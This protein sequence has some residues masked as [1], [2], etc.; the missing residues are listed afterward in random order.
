MSV[1]FAVASNSDAAAIAALRMATSRALTQQ[2]GAG[3][4]SFAAESE[5]SVQAELRSSTVVFAREAGTI[6]A[7]AR[8]STRNPWIGRTD[9]FTPCARP[10]FLTA[11]AVT[12]NRQRQGVGRWLLLQAR[13]VSRELGGE[14]LRLDSYQ[15]PAGAGD[16]YRKCGF[17][18]VYRG[19]YNGTP[20]IWFETML[21]QKLS[22][23]L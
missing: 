4:W 19:D 10:I 18:E 17:T 7:T 5:A 14:A 21:P 16:F 20:L 3:P 13:R 8:L 11:M 12:P 2:F 15:G 23:K 22:D 1:S 9:F 6:I